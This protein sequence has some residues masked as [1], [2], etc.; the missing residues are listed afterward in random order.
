MSAREL[1]QLW[2]APTDLSVGDVGQPLRCLSTTY[3]FNAA[4]LEHELLPRFLGLRYDDKESRSLYVL[5]RDHRLGTVPVAVLVD[6]GMVS[7]EQSTLRWD[8][9]PV[10]VPH[11]IQHAKI[12]L[13]VWE[14]AVRVIIGSA[15][16]TAAAYRTNR[17]MVSVLDFF[18]AANS[19]PRG[20]LND[21]LDFIERLIGF[22]RCA[23]ALRGRIVNQVVET[24]KL[25]AR[26]TSM[27]SDFAAHERPRVHFVSG[28]PSVSSRKSDSVIDAALERWGSRRVDN[29]T[30]L[31]PFVDESP[32][33]Q[34]HLIGK[35]AAL[36]GAQTAQLAI[37]L[38]ARRLESA[39]ANYQV[40]APGSFGQTCTTAF[41]G[42]EWSAFV[43]PRMNDETCE[44]A[45][46]AKALLLQGG[47]ATLLLMGSSN[48]TSRGMGTHQ[49][50]IE[51][52]LCFIDRLKQ[53]DG[54]SWHE[55]L[56][57]DVWQCEIE[58]DA[59]VNWAETAIVGDATDDSRG[60]LPAFFQCA[61]VHA[62]SRGEGE[63]MGGRVIVTFNLTAA[64]P[65]RWRLSTHKHG[66][67]DVTEIVRGNGKWADTQLE[68]RLPP[69][70]HPSSIRVLEVSWQGADDHVERIALMP[71]GLRASTDLPLSEEFAALTAD[72][73]LTCLIAGRE[74]AGHAAQRSNERQWRRAGQPITDPLR[75]V[76]TD[77]FMLYRTRRLGR[78]LARAG[79]RLGDTPATPAAMSY[80]LLVDPLGVLSLASALVRQQRDD[81]KSRPDAS[82][83]QGA[84]FA[85]AEIVLLVGHAGKSAQGRARASGLNVLP[86]FREAVSRILELSRTAVEP[87]SPGADVL[88]Y[89]RHCNE[90]A[91]RLLRGHHAIVKVS[92]NAE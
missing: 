31:T 45:L 5:E 32:D 39:E 86:V 8:Q 58:E 22:T 64:E 37:L 75:T 55:R 91:G 7:A 44:R 21:V 50:N 23:D 56:P 2:M 6:A 24:R 40:Q 29:L 11:G 36:K 34:A 4:Y 70:L 74:P 82:G 71:V 30:L 68:W 73:I 42:C 63:P 88:G 20:L 62:E 28:L 13:L 54:L 77:G 15:N 57:V 53:R 76:R 61:T 48:F 27:R 3:T 46:H 60:T 43:L 87:Y 10:F 83:V 90:Q 16:L 35:L 51:A 80:R 9:I 18:D 78:A 12:S 85:L 92:V 84:V 69:H 72:E 33:K 17:E 79:A 59:Q 14:H 65:T 38:P 89:L 47:D 49:P 25:T 19:C 52:N 1:S 66:D 81:E 67:R 41:P 26:W